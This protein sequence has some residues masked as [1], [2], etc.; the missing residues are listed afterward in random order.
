[1][2]CDTYLVLVLGVLN[3][4]PIPGYLTGI[5]TYN[6][7]KL[8]NQKYVSALP[9]YV[10]IINGIFSKLTWKKKNPDEMEIKYQLVL[11]GMAWSEADKIEYNT[12]G[13]FQISDSNNPVYYVVRRTGNAYI[14]QEK[15]TCHAFDP[16]AIIP[17]GEIVFPAKFMTP[18]KI[19][20]IGITI[21]MKKYL[22]W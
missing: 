4:S 17:E 9:S 1:M 11:Y 19:V 15:Y 12:I 3:N 7:V 8:S 22:S 6:H 2:L 20:F 21:Q 13:A 14:L 10:A 5:K 18:M 16:A